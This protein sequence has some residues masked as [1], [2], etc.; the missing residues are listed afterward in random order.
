VAVP[1]LLV[2]ADGGDID[3]TQRKRGE[4]E[5]AEAAIP[6]ARVRWFVGDHDVHAQHP[7]ELAGVMHDMTAD[8][9]LA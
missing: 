1:A 6:N 3:G 2:P 5:A 8:G 7:R 9:F 4:V